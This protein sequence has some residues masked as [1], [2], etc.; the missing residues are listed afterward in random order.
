MS[1]LGNNT[2][3]AR[4]RWVKAGLTGFV[5]L[6]VLATLGLGHMSNY[7]QGLLLVAV[8]YS[9]LALSLDMVAGI[10]GLFSLGHAGFFAIGAYLSAILINNY[11]WNLF[12]TLGFVMLVNVIAGYIIGALS[13]RV[14]GL[15]FAIVTY[16]FTLIVVVVAD[17]TNITG[18]Y[19]GIPGAI[20]PNFPK[21]L[22]FL[23]TSV[24]WALSGALLITLTIVWSIRKSPA[25]PVLLAIRDAEPF[26]QS[27]GVKTSRTK[28]SIFAL[29]AALAAMAGWTFCFLGFVAPSDFSGTASINILVMV[30]LGGI[31]TLL[32]PIVGASFISLFPV[33]VNWNPLIQEILFGAIF[34]FVVIAVPEGFVGLVTRLFRRAVPNSWRRNVDGV[35]NVAPVEG[36]RPVED[37]ANEVGDSSDYALEADGINF[38]YVAGVSVLKNVSLRARRGTI[39]GLIGP[40]GSGKS[41]LVNLLSGQLKTK[42]GS[43]SL[44]GH[45]V[46]RLDAASRPHYGLMRTFQT[47]V[48]VKEVTTRENV[49]VGLFHKYRRIPSRS[50]IWPLLPSGRRDGRELVERSRGALLDA[51]LSDTWASTKVAD[52]PHGVEQ[53][54]QLAAACA[55]TPSILLLDEPLAGLSG[56]EVEHVSHILRTLRD[57]GTTILV[58][59]HQTRFIFDVCDDV[60]VIA[61]GELV[62]SGTAAE[63]RVDDR[64]REVYLGQ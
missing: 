3:T 14:S 55:G 28:V 2:S 4:S 35:A 51:G 1:S 18:G 45:R 36:S 22:S 49:T 37:L 19:Q 54:T 38:S 5:V 25:Y 20:F 24:V 50:V 15:Y 9:I 16:I 29:S 11:H 32:G 60:T 26:A 30:I 39:H 21:S 27:A 46:E 56:G 43:I 58:V 34:I 40:N 33:V 42:I 13:L 10:L 12:L 59:E 48:M 57:R 6:Y 63:V 47:A 62:R 17:Q 61:A 52:V 53:L 7:D 8:T 64:V 31:N 23:G 41:T 44:H